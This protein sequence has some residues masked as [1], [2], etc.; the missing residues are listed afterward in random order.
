MKSLSSFQRAIFTDTI[1]KYRATAYISENDEIIT[2]TQPSGIF[3]RISRTNGLQFRGSE[4]EFYYTGV[5]KPQTLE[6]FL[7]KF[8]YWK[9]QIF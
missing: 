6:N 4:G 8:W 9:K 1:R 2:P 3:L 5:F 7:E